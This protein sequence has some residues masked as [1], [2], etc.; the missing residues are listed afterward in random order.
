MVL[1][2]LQARY[3]GKGRVASSETQVRAAASVPPTRAEQL[4]EMGGWPGKW[5][6]GLLRDT[7]WRA[8]SSEEQARAAESEPPT[9]A[10]RE[11]LARLL[12]AEHPRVRLK[13]LEVLH[14]FADNAAGHGALPNETW[15]GPAAW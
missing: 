9:Q 2:A 3:L 10:E 12:R 4:R 6:G 15:H 7:E 1:A 13:A 5:E 11:S 14:A 8:A